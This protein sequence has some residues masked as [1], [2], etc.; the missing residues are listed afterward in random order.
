MQINGFG[1]SAL[2]SLTA[3][4]NTGLTVKSP[5]QQPQ[6]SE[7]PD[8]A[9]VDTESARLYVP[10]NSRSATALQNL[11]MANAL[12]RDVYNLLD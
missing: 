8:R 5:A 4:S 3:A 2:G 6:V 11:S 10:V 9:D 1:A 7:S 12:P